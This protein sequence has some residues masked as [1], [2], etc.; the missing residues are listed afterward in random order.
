MLTIAGL[1]DYSKE[2]V[3]EHEQKKRD[4]EIFDLRV[5]DTHFGMILFDHLN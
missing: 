1:H 2:G 3:Q 5:I 4:V